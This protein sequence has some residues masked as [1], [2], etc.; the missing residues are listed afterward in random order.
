MWYGF[1]M[2]MLFPLFFIVCIAFVLIMVITS[3]GGMGGCG[4]GP[5]RPYDTENENRRLRGEVEK[6][7][8]E[9]DDL[10]LKVQK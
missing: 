5:H 2:F 7:R 4:F 1:P 3:R 8:S 10:R 6:L 9:L